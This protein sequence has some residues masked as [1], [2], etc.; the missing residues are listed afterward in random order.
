M[1]RRLAKYGLS[2]LAILLIAGCSNDTDLETSVEE[3]VP[4]VFE[5]ASKPLNCTRATYDNNSTW[6]TGID[7]AVKCTASSLGETTV[8]T[9]KNYVTADNGSGGIKLKGK[10]DAVANTFY[11]LLKNDSKSFCMWYP[12]SAT[13]PTSLNVDADQRSSNNCN[14]QEF[15][16]YDLLYAEVINKTASNLP[17]A[18]PV[19][20]YHQMA[21]L[22]VHIA[23]VP[24]GETVQSVQLGANNVAITASDWSPTAAN[25]NASTT[26]TNEG[27]GWTLGTQGS[28]INLRATT[29]GT[30]YTCILP[31]QTI[32]TASTTLLTITTSR[33][34]YTCKGTVKLCAG[35]HHT[36][37][38]TIEQEVQITATV[39]AWTDGGTTSINWHSN[40]TY[41]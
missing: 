3:R 30:D 21:R 22:S 19:N 15:A 33:D 32:G 6:S 5:L 7:I 16:S 12:Y 38:V 18:G 4:V 24:A 34:T 28:T 8:G 23:Y 10:G 39:T 40:G 1:Y 29:A 13:M 41:N 31:P 17:L 2:M 14:D 20:F 26:S 37:N 9:V 27:A 35:N 36:L 25:D 11:W